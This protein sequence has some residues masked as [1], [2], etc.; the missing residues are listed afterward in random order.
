MGQYI[1]MYDK[2]CGRWHVVGQE[3]KKIG[4]DLYWFC[5]CSCDAHTTRYVRSEN[6]RNGSSQSCGCLNREISAEVCRSRAKPNKYDLSGKHGVGWT[7]NGDEFYFDIEDYDLIK[8][9]HWHLDRDGYIVACTG[10][11]TV[12]MHRIVTKC[13]SGYDVDHIYHKPNDNRK[14][15]LRIC[16]R[17]HNIMN[18]KIPS[19]NTSG[20][21]GVCWDKSRNLWEAYIKINQRKKHLG[22]FADFQD[23]VEARR[24]AENELFGEFSY[25]NSIGQQNSQERLGTNCDING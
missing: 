15:Q 2:Q 22:R 20:V 6:L 24:R 17:Q 11:T 16:K 25:E 10:N 4:D 8:D 1:D 18:S 7:D 21:K 19:N 5:E 3:P 14:S 12:K 9:Y 13:P 23:A